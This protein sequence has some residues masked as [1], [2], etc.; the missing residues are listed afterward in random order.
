MSIGMYRRR[1]SVGPKVQRR[2]GAVV[3]PVATHAV[4]LYEECV[5]D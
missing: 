3:G 2:G 5:L 1:P 4:C